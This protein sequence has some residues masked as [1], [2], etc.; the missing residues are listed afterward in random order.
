MSKTSDAGEAEGRVGSSEDNLTQ[1]ERAAWCA[2]RQNF[3]ASSQQF[4]SECFK[5]F[6]GA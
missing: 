2:F 3:K 5:M 1:A 6:C 4:F